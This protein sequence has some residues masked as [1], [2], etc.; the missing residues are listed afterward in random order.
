MTARYAATTEVPVAKTRA[1]IEALITDRY[2]ADQFFAAIDRIQGVIGFTMKDRQ[3]RFVLRLPDPGDKRFTTYRDRY[4]HEQL[5][6]A[7]AAQKQWEQAGRSAWRALLLVIKAK[8][9]AVE[10]G[11]SEFEHEF[12]ANIVLPDG[13]L[14]A[15][16]VRPRIE[17]AY[18]SGN[19]PPLLPHY[20]DD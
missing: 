6:S 9:E 14:V 18:A 13:Q 11:I 1:A 17:Q 20:G 10:A 7:D 19:M 3:V 15:H 12:L 8:L 4:G 5:R 16:H 2:G